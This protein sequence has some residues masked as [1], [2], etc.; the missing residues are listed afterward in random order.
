ME[1]G[2]R[3]AREQAAAASH[4]VAAAPVA[5][6]KAASTEHAP[7]ASA[8]SSAAQKV[9]GTSA[10]HPATLGAPSQPSTSGHQPKKESADFSTTD[11]S[12]LSG[13]KKHY[14]EWI[15]N[16]TV[17]VRYLYLM[18]IIRLCSVLTGEFEEICSRC[19]ILCLYFPWRLHPRTILVG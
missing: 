2:A 17:E 15:A 5:A 6:K 12:S 9:A 19:N 8:S 18:W 11:M 16:I 4:K 7:V 14:N 3:L 13:D 1:E 10:P